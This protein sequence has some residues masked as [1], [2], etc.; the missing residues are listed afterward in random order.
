MAHE[1]RAKLDTI[2]QQLAEVKHRLDRI[3]HLLEM[4]D[5]SV[6]DAR[7][8]IRE[9]QQRKEQLERAADEARQVL[10]ERRQ[11][12]DSAEVIARFAEE[13]GEFLR[14]SEL[15][16]TKTFI[17]SF[18]Q[19]ITVRPGR[20]VIHYSIPMPEDS[21]IGPSDAAEIALDRGVMSTVHVGGPGWIRTSDRA[22]MSRLL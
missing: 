7:D 5:L 6:D 8:R 18:V 19:R 17:K 21:P 4:T 12:I 9:H 13:M 11:L 2:E 15:T 10:S 16:E 14:T 22:V 1:Q 20:A 3:W